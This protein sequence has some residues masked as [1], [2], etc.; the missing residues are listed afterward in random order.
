MRVT[1]RERLS[2][3]HELFVCAH[4][5]TSLP[6]KVGCGIHRPTSSKVRWR[7]SVFLKNQLKALKLEL[8]IFLLPK[9]LP[10]QMAKPAKDRDKLGCKE[11]GC[12]CRNYLQLTPKPAFPALTLPSSWVLP[13]PLGGGGMWAGTMRRIFMKSVFSVLVHT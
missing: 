7:F 2:D 13:D 5:C 9:G 8:Y 1:R 10:E 4:A 3:A 12:D 6:L 11:R